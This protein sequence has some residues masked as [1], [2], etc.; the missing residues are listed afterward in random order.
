[1]DYDDLT[2]AL[3][4]KLRRL[5]PR[6]LEMG[7]GQVLSSETE[8]DGL[9]DSAVDCEERVSVCRAV[10]CS[11]IFALTAAEV[12]KGLIKWDREKP[13]F[14]ARE[15]SGF[16]SHFNS[17]SRRCRIWEDRPLRCRRYDCT[18]EDSFWQDVN[19]HRLKPGVFD[20]LKKI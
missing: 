17:R 9:T 8:G 11:F 5:V 19:C 10:C 15:P 13:C 6:L 18:Q 3:R 14:I 2:P 7:L 20:H 1:M 12:E 16:C 4:E